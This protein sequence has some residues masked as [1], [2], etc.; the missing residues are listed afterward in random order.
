MVSKVRMIRAG[1]WMGVLALGGCA[2]HSPRVGMGTYRQYARSLADGRGNAAD[3]QLERASRGDAEAIHA[4]FG[5]T[6]TR[7]RQ[8]FVFAGEDIGELSGEMDFL[9]Y[10]LGDRRFA[11]VLLRESVPTRSAVRAFLSLGRL[12]APTERTK[13]VF[14]ATPQV[15]FP[16][17][18]ATR[19]YAVRS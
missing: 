6:V 16:A 13:A 12:E 5:R 7:M 14:E 18:V 15:D 2:D 1:C 3:R 10:S 19:K 4:C 11:E 8:P 9:F 17:D